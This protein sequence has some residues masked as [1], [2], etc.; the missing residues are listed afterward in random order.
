MRNKSIK[1]LE[2]M[3]KDRGI[4]DISK[5]KLQQMNEKILNGLDYETR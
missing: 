2:N 5:E 3:A 1:F 4:T